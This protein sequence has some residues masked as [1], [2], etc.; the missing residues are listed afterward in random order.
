MKSEPIKI[1]FLLPTY[2][3]GGAERTFLNLLKGIDKN[4][5]SIC[6]VTSR[7]VY[8]YFQGL[9]IEKFIPIE[10]LGLAPG[11]ISFG[12]FIHDIKRVASLLKKE[13][14]DLAFGIMHYASALLVFAKK[15][16]NIKVKVV[17]S[18][19]G[20]LTE[21]LR[22][23]E[24]KFFRKM[25]LKWVFSFFCRHADGLVV[26]STGMKEECI[27]D[28]RA[29]PERVEVIPNSIDINDIKRK[30]EEEIDIDMPDCRS[31]RPAGFKFIVT[32]GRL[33]KE[34]NTPVLLKVFSELRKREEVKLL[35]VGDGSERKTLELLSHDLN[36]ESDVIFVGYQNNPYKYIRKSDIFVHTCLFEGF[37]N[38]IIEAMACG[39][40]VI[41][42]DCPYGPRDIVKHGGNG[43]LVPMN[44]EE[45]LVDA[46]LTLLHNRKL[47]DLIASR[48]TERA[49][50]F[51][52]HKMVENYE[53]FLQ[54]V[55]DVRNFPSPS[56][57]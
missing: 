17:A 34:K 47:R 43:L 54:Q 3:F 38:V 4:R 6:L 20:P 35:I 36:I 22:H 16:F 53:S 18:P 9:D 39:V 7:D 19:R 11:F 51:S 42:V 23:F 33:Q 21:Y 13:T 15:L 29:I 50:D 56:H 8:S 37:A 24:H 55:Q 10:D 30:A 12:R 25:Y 27:R 1:L 14:P 32:S 52:V 46:I 49:M 44:D 45:A 28:Y 5:F 2:V 31:G 41:A 57:I 26:S 40:P 48:G